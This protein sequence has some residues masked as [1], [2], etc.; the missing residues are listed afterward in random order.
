MLNPARSRIAIM[1]VLMVMLSSCLVAPEVTPEIDLEDLFENPSE[2]SKPWVYW[3]WMRANAT[4]EGITRDL[5][6]MA[7]TGIGGAYLMPI[8]NSAA[9]ATAENLTLADP[10]ADPLSDHWWDLVVF[11][12]NEAGRF[13]LRLAMNACDGWALAGGVRL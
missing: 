1:T 12:V 6:A 7:E 10:P 9:L 11:A 13:G 3:Y 4:R 8:G 5:E 2:E